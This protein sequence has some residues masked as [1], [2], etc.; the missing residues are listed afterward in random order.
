VNEDAISVVVVDDDAALCSALEDGLR[1]R[2]IDVRSHTDPSMA[3]ADLAQS[4]PDAVISDI[5]MPK[6]DGL[7]LC[8]Q[9]AAR[10]PNVPV[11]LITAYGSMDSAV[12]AI[13]SGA[14]DFI[15][16]P[17]QIDALELVVRRAVEV[18][19]LRAELTR[20]REEVP[21]PRGRG[22]FLGES[23]PM[24]GLD[25]VI[26]RVAPT[27]ATVLILGESGTGKE[28][29]ARTLHE[30]SGR[31]GAFV[32]VHCAAVPETLLES[33]LFGHAR[34]AFT[35]ARADR[36]GLFVLADGGT[37]FLDE[38]GEL[39]LG[40]QA[41]MLRALQERRV[42]Q[43]GGNDEIP[44]D[45]RIIAA[46]NRDLEASIAEGTFRQDLFFRI[47]VV[48]IVLPPLRVR[49]SDVLLLAQHFVVQAARHHRKECV[50]LT[51]AVAEALLRHGWP[52]N[53]RELQNVIE[54]AVIL[55]HHD[56]LVLDDL[57]ES[58]ASEEALGGNAARQGGTKDFVPLEEVERHY[59]L[60]VLD[61]VGGNRSVAAR[62]LGIDRRT[63]I[64]K[65]HAYGVTAA[66]S[67]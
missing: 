52:G 38:I 21:R 55:T 12:A 35:D 29:V 63:I 57:P 3:L 47:S 65:L 53:V 5:T 59:I 50:G 42:R 45:V 4:E 14:Y 41:K 36:T 67:E 37:L 11:I 40:M 61:A 44:V 34:G 7:W 16:K 22:L 8:E 33:E 66:G 10:R 32:P 46:T 58:L 62:I 13:R 15:T 25:Q 1:H 18:R 43:V 31:A 6:R 56:R 30:R 39:P 19:R 28:L 9:I 49:G 54:R 17:V 23:A 24:R 27:D 20:L 48:P 64:R 2:G 51:A 60:E 26:S